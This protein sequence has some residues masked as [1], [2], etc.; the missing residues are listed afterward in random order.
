MYFI[1]IIVGALMA[2]GGLLTTLWYVVCIKPPKPEALSNYTT[3]PNAEV[4][5]D[6]GLA[7]SS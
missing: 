4:D 2:L 3:L 1:M 5:T 7:R 6:E